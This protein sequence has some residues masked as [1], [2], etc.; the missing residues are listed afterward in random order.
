MTPEQRHEIIH[1][2]HSGQSMRGIGKDLQ[3][4]P[5]TVSRALRQH[6]A[7]RR[8]GSSSADSPVPSESRTSKLDAHDTKI[9]NLLERYP[10]ITSK[11]I[12]EEIQ[13]DG[14]A[15]GYS[16]LSERIARLRPRDGKAFTDCF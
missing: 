15:G 7:D 13:A 16:I 11:R 10:K 5:Q 12:M 1:R 14:Y 9:R 4:S 2:F 6:A 3:L 8:E